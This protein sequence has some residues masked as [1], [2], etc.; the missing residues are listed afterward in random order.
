MK[1][2]SL[3]LVLVATGCTT[4]WSHE[5][6]G[7]TDFYRDSARCEAMAGGGGYNQIADNGDPMLRGYNAGAAA[8]AAGSRRRIF[9]RCMMGEGWYR[10]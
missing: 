1:Y 6:K 10:E 3:I 8:A 4:T 5:T 9:E 7:Q 2:L